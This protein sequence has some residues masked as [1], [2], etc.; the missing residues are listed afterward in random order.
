MVKSVPKVAI[1]SR[2]EP[3]VT[4]VEI[5]RACGHVETLEVR[6]DPARSAYLDNAR[7]R[8]C[9]KCY[10]QKQ[11]EA[12]GQAVA[13]GKRCELDGSE[14][15]VAWASGVR[16][17][18]AVEF[19]RAINDA[20]AWAKEVMAKGDALT[21]AVAKAR[22][23]VA[24]QAISD[25]FLGKVTWGLLDQDG[26]EVEVDSGRARFWIDTRELELRDFVAAMLPQFRWESYRDWEPLF[27]AQAEDGPI[28][29]AE[30]YVAP[31]PPAPAKPA[32]AKAAPA[33]AA[34]K[35]DLFDDDDIPF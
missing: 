16:Q 35:A 30:E 23:K 11:T 27:R 6:G 13:E 8:D 28:D 7:M 5:T 4:Q 3:Q 10:R 20:A 18:R 12:D 14:K 34:P 29:D 19:G 25:L 1:R 17:R 24:Q 9:S 31:P 2:G 33:K 15:Q 32:P 22:T 21:L 26:N